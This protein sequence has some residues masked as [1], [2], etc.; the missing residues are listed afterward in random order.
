MPRGWAVASLSGSLAPVATRALSRGR[1][2]SCGPQVI[3]CEIRDIGTWFSRSVRRVSRHTAHSTREGTQLS[4]AWTDVVASARVFFSRV[5][6]PRSSDLPRSRIRIPGRIRA[7]ARA[8]PAIRIRVH[9]LAY[10]ARPTR[11]LVLSS[12]SPRLL[13]NYREQDPRFELGKIEE[14]RVVENF[15][16]GVV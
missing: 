11:P 4:V 10:A 2:T 8:R 15:R 7:R 16:A 3:Y 1:P 6:I 14:Q 12:A 9:Y 13:A 5:R